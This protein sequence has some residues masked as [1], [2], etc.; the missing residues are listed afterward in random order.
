[1]PV[2]A[3]VMAAQAQPVIPL[4]YEIDGAE[5]IR[6]GFDPSFTDSD[7]SGARG[8]AG[9]G[10]TIIISRCSKIP[11]NTSLPTTGE[12]LV[13]RKN[14][15]GSYD[16]MEL[17]SDTV[18][19]VPGVTLA[20]PRE[21]YGWS[22]AMEGNTLV[23]GASYY[24]HFTSPTSTDPT[25]IVQDPYGL[26][27][28]QD[29]T[30][31]AF[32]YTRTNASSDQWD[33][34]QVLYSPEP[35]NG[36]R[37]GHKV[38]FH[39][40][41][42]LVVATRAFV[43]GFSLAPG[44]GCQNIRSEINVYEVSALTNQ[45]EIVQEIVPPFMDGEAAFGAISNGTSPDVNGNCVGGLPGDQIPPIHS[46]Q[47]SPTVSGSIGYDNERARDITVDGDWLAAVA[48]QGMYVYE[49]N[50]VSSQYD[51][52]TTVLSSSLSTP[53][54]A[55]KGWTDIGMDN[56]L[57]AVVSK[58]GLGQPG[59]MV[60]FEYESSTDTWDEKVVTADVH[61]GKSVS[62]D[63]DHV[64]VQGGNVVWKYIRAT[65]ELLMVGEID[66]NATA[67]IAPAAHAVA[68]DGH[69][70]IPDTRESATGGISINVRAI[71]DC[72]YDLN[73]DGSLNFFDISD[74][75]TLFNASDLQADYALPYGVL[76]IDDIN[77]Y[78]ALHG[79]GCP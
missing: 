49:Y 46:R 8:I 27:G 6:A 24:P 21:W 5:D 43:P 42:L 10:D 44:S 23:V 9:E 75:M 72:P 37:Y 51:L 66:F 35:V 18:V 4:E 77:H 76:D 25:D 1:M 61:A 11:N 50:S 60:L 31:A 59:G 71:S 7:F 32:V 14:A 56:G 64:L 26:Y 65:E 29:L 78:L 63:N 74:Y 19:G 20:Q 53:I 36:E 38:M 70:L 57:I 22:I 40:G 34:Q 41:R 47:E 55:T 39:D 17:N 73:G 62:V 58:P 13:Y 48:N 52:H 15:S 79:S 67:A 16:L 33:L 69:Y 68:F 54:N 2:A 45:Y 12:F 3:L 28:D 30:G